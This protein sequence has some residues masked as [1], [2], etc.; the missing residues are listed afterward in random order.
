MHDC[1]LAAAILG[2]IAVAATYAPT[3]AASEERVNTAGARRSVTLTVYTDFA[4]VRDVRTVD[5]QAGVNRLA[6]EDIAPLLAP[7]TVIFSNLSGRQPVWVNDQFYD[8]IVLT[9][10]AV[11]SNAVGHEV[12]VI[13]TDPT[14]GREVRRET[15]TLLSQDGPT[16]Q[17]A[18]RVETGVPPFSRIVY[19]S[20][21]SGL[22]H[23]PALVADIGTASAQQ[24]LLGVSYIT[25]GLGWTT[26]YVCDLNPSSTAMDVEAL[27]TV[28]NTT[29]ASFGNARLQFVAGSVQR[30]TPATLQAA[31]TEDVY[32]AAAK[33]APVYNP[34]NRAAR[35]AL[36]EYYLY[37]I[38]HEVSIAPNQAKQVAL[39]AADAVPTTELFELDEDESEALT[40]PDGSAQT[41][42]VN[43]VL[44]FRNAGRGLGIPLPPGTM[45]VYKRSASGDEQFVG[46]DAIQT[47]PKNALV[48]LSVGQ[49]F[50]VT[51]VQTQT[52]Y[53]EERPYPTSPVVNHF[54]LFKVVLSN[55]KSAAVRVKVTEQMSGDWRIT[56]ESLPH[57]KP[58]SETAAWTVAVPANGSATLEYGVL[59]RS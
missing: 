50:D 24:A 46:D 55:A 1:R 25:N 56:S 18:D 21:P 27:A 43:V 42:P 15:A 57:E 23:E 37:T 49:S 58:T 17:F 39:F 2:A 26:D 48:R 34:N 32:S 38:P 33:A 40:T 41:P 7:E 51:A 54:S 13:T 30:I 29:A 47:T 53:S 6:F 20:A 45:H 10:G 22:R 19:L 4:T 35:E 11:Q 16:L 28:S 44:Q 5:L 8:P 59:Q 31:M 9:A 14:T 36:L 12:V 3:Q 52:S